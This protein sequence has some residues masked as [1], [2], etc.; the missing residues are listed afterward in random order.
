MPQVVLAILAHPDDCEFVCAGTVIRLARELG[1]SAHVATMTPGDCGS[2]EYPPEEIAALRRAEAAEAAGLIGATY[3]CLE[4]RDL[5]V[6]FNPTAL[7]KVVRLMVEVRPD[8]VLTHSPD[9]YHLDHEMTSTLVRA[10]AFAAPV[11]NFL[12]GRWPHPPLERIPHLYYCD[13]IDGKDQFGREIAPGFRVDVSSRID[14]KSEMLARHVSQRRWLLKH[15]GVDD[16]V[17]SMRAWSAA[18]GRAAGVAFAEGFRQH[19]GHSYPQ[20]NWLAELLAR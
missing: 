7:E 16:F 13:P 1:W 8:I 18:Q 3:H 11:P 14:A 17:E 4:E 19:L 10:A 2:T 20:N 9:D 15:H 12:H 6:T 5:R